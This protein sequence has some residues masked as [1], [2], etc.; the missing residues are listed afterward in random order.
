MNRAER[1][2]A[3]AELSPG[4]S[5]PEVAAILGISRSTVLRDR[6]LLGIDSPNLRLY[7]ASTWER[8]EEML[9]DGCSASEVGRTLGM[10]VQAVLL[11]FPCRGW[12]PRQSNEHRR[13]LYGSNWFGD[14]RRRP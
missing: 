4:R 2:R 9:A 11:H 8:A 5:C 14:D 12:T 3:V 1:R 13:A 10:T 6:R 7:D